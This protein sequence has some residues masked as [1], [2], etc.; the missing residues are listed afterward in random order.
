MV[1]THAKHILTGD[2]IVTK[3][4]TLAKW[5]SKNNNGAVFFW[6]EH[7]DVCWNELFG[8]LRGRRLI[9]G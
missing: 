8:M 3:S 5:W 4:N 6:G 2:L 1:L 7:R 9:D